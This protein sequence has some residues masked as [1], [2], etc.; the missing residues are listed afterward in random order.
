MKSRGA[1]TAAEAGF[2]G[3]AKATDSC[4]KLAGAEEGSVQQGPVAGL[5]LKASRAPAPS[6]CWGCA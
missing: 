2:G 5:Q 4:S 6:S 3:P 1:T